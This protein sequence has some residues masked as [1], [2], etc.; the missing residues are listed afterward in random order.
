MRQYF[1]YVNPYINNSWIPIDYQFKANTKALEGII[2]SN[3]CVAQGSSIGDPRILA[4][5]EVD[6]DGDGNMVVPYNP[7]GKDLPSNVFSKILQQFPSITNE[8]VEEAKDK[9]ERW[10]GRDDITISG[11]EVIIPELV[12]E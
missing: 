5:I 10:T 12:I 7:A 1:T 4:Y 3:L 9:V 6:V 11:D 8:T 2:S